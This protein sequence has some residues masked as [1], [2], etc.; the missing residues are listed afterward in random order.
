MS[1]SIR[2][3]QSS[4]RTSPAASRAKRH[5]KGEEAFGFWVKALKLPTPRRNFRFHPIRKFEIDW[6]WPEQKIGIEIQG[7]IWIP[8]GKGA[9]S[10]PMNIVRDMTKHNLLLDLGWRV[11]HFTPREVIDGVAIQHIDKVLRAADTSIAARLTAEPVIPPARE[12]TQ[13]VLD[14]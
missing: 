14:L 3:S 12:Q 5:N 6:A 1:P 2:T 4:G 8:G 11:W 10:R 7:G 13:E 9:H